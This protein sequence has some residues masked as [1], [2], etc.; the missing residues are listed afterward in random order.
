MCGYRLKF[1]K[2]KLSLLC[3]WLICWLLVVIRLLF[4]FFFRCS[5]LLEIRIWFWCGF[6]SRLM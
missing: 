1:W 6:F 4:L 3:S 5:F 2:M